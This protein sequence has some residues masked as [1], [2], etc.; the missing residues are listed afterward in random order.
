MS[1]TLLEVPAP[2]IRDV[3]ELR[4]DFHAHP[5]LGFEEVRTAK[6]V[7]ERLKGLGY[8]VRTG[9]GQTGVIGILR[10]KRPGKTVLLRADM[11]CLPIEE[12]SGVEFA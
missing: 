10:T 1:A 5:E 8:E 11:D 12:R 9:L 2:V 6:I 3:V 7:A 4:R